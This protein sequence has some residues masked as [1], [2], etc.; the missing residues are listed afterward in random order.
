MTKKLE[1]VIYRQQKNQIIKIDSQTIHKDLK[2]VI[3]NMAEN[4]QENMNK[5][6]QEMGIFRTHLEIG[7][8]MEIPGIK[9]KI[10]EIKIY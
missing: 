5:M 7:K 1:G 9:S 3:I 2:R 8:K 10:A 4:L 6:D